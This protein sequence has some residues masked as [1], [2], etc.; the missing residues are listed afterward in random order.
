M[1]RII[2][3]QPITLGKLDQFAFG[4]YPS[5]GI[6]RHERDAYNIYFVANG[7]VWNIPEN[8]LISEPYK[9]E[10][11]LEG[12]SVETM[13]KTLAVAQKPELAIELI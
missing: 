12:V 9:E 10:P 7:Q 5:V 6:Y 4:S 8:Q 2:D 3:I 13:L 1:K 11:K